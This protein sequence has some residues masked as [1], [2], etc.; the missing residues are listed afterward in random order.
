[1]DDPAKS[2][3]RKK[4]LPEGYICKACGEGGHAIYEC[5]L[6]TERK[7][8]KRL[9]DKSEVSLPR[10]KFFVSGIPHS[11]T[12]EE[13]IT[14]LAENGIKSENIKVRLAMRE[15]SYESKGFGIVT[16]DA[17]DTDAMLALDKATIGHRQVNI[18]LDDPSAKKRKN[19]SSVSKRC[20]RCG[21]QHSSKECTNP[22]ICY[23]CKSTDHLSNECPN[24]VNKK[25]ITF[26]DTDS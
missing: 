3:K 17:S 19:S 6:Y 15:N 20:Y 1:M 24:K 10:Q 11:H 26:T 18:K 14:F 21:G 4:P 25:K 13:V 22:R 23:R 12:S 8:K 5:N 16:V 7:K 2:Q 9:E